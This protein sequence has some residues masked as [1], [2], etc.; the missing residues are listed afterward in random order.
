MQPKVKR[1]DRTTVLIDQEAAD[2]LRA[3]SFVTDETQASIIH[4]GIKLAVA[5]LPENRKALIAHVLAKK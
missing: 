4:R 3:A 5:G 1:L 2:I